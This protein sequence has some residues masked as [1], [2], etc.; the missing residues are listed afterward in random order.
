MWKNVLGE[1]RMNCPC[2][3][4]PMKK[5]KK[6]GTIYYRCKQCE[7]EIKILLKKEIKEK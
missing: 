4:K 1:Q 5:C 6:D 7:I 3:E 2:C